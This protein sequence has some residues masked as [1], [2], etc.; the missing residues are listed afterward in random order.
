LHKHAT[1][2][3]LSNILI[4]IRQ[5]LI[6]EKKGQNFF[7]NLISKPLLS[8]KDN[9]ILFKKSFYPSLAK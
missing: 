2:K 3:G 1:T 4:E 5:D 7:A 8:N 9:Y 6:I